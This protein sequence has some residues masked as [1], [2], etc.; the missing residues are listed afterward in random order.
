VRRAAGIL[1]LPLAAL[2]TACTL[3]PDWLRPEA[4]ADQ[5]YTQQ[6]KAEQGNSDQHVAMG[7]KITGDWWTLYRSDPMNQVLEQAIARNRSL[8]GAQATLVAAQEAVNQAEGGLFPQL[9]ASSGGQRQHI[10]GAQFGQKKLPPGFPPYAN[11]FRVGATVSYA[12]DIWGSTR[13]TIEQTEALADAQDF[14]L[15]AAYLTITGNAV[16]EMLT[17]ASLNTQIA[18]V[19]GIIADDEQNLRLVHSEV[20]AGVATQLDVETA[21]SQ[22]ATDR[23]LLP[24]LRQQVNAARHALAVLVGRAPSQWMPPDLNLDQITLPADL[25]V[26]LPSDLVRQRPDI[27]ASEAQL[28]AST[29]AIGIATAALYP[30]ITL[31]G[32]LSQQA[33]TVDTLFHGASD[34]WSFGANISA[35]IFHGG[36]LTAQKRRAQANFESSRD[37][38]EETVLLAFAQ[39]ADVLD[40][41]D[42]DTQLLAEEQQAL[43]AAQASL[44][45]TRLAYS[46]GSIG[47]LQ[48]VDA[49]RIVEQARLGYERARAQR[50]LDTAQL[51]VAMGGGWWDWREHEGEAKPVS[52]LAPAK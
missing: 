52:L 20:N 37:S 46:L 51:F 45:L 9:D 15:D 48:V 34:V 28:H 11:L 21:R 22:L 14:T 1:A 27:L 41:L 38:Y 32:A 42:Q 25:P 17:I 4:P 13:R 47:V 30:S 8:A 31:T 19:Q 50:Y 24:P 40:A 43:F 12:V 29:A 39:V 33:I 49:Q 2:A 3:G 44:D 36:A 5:T 6:G 26:S 35:P 23:T 18:T 10:N 16:V 7:Q